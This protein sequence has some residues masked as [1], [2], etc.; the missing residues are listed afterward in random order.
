MIDEK[1]NLNRLYWHSRRGMWELDL[2]LV[3]FLEFGFAKLSQDEQNLYVQMLAEEDQD[4]FSWLVKRETNLA[5][6]YKALAEKII[7][8]VKTTDAKPH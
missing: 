6:K 5:G 1:I 2:I 8:F 4:I 3:P 7:E